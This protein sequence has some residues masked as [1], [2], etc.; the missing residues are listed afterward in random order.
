[1]MKWW[2]VGMLAIVGCVKQPIPQ[3]TTDS[4]RTAKTVQEMQGKPIHTFRGPADILGDTT[5]NARKPKWVKEK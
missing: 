2:F 3:P 1:M 5:K 4:A